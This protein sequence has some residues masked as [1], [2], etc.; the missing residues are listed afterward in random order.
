MGAIL[1][2]WPILAYWLTLKRVVLEEVEVSAQLSK[3]TA[4][5]GEAY[6]G[7]LKLGSRIT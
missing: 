1:A 7:L 6:F 4:L 2:D 3:P 5:N